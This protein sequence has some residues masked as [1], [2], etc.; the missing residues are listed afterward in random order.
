MIREN[1]PGNHFL[2]RRQLLQGAAAALLPF[3]G[4]QARAQG[5]AKPLLVGG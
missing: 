2:R 5:T 4:N 1:P 3:F